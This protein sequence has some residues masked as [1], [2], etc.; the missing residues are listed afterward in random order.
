ME[1]DS[2]CQMR[3]LSMIDGRGLRIAGLASHPREEPRGSVLIVPGYE[4]RIPHFGVLARYLVRHGYS[5]VRFDLTNHVGASDG[6]IFDYSLSGM[7]ADIR[8]VLAEADWPAEPP[9]YLVAPSMAARASARALTASATCDGVV[10][11]VPVVNLRSTW[12]QA[13]E[14]DPL[15]VWERREVTDPRTPC[16]VLKHDIA[17]ACA[18]DV[19]ESGLDDLVGTTNDLAQVAS[20]VTAVAL[21]RDDWVQIQ[22][23]G[24]ALSGESAWPRRVIALD[25]SS[26]DMTHNPP[27]MREMMDSILGALAEFG[28]AP[29]GPVDH[30]TFDELV[31]TVTRERHWARSRYADLQPQ[32]AL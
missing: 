14:M 18:Q 3:F 31:E 19:L 30:L 17:Y 28:G 20:P 5:A 12:S 21:E 4:Q 13:L 27:V 25:A 29:A 8:A 2:E 16:R 9:R 24:E 23:V 7:V 15:G 26:H 1:L 10:L 32:E 22:D 6:D 11:L